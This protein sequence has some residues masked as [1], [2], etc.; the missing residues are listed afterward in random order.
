ML[1]NA[2]GRVQ[3]LLGQRLLWDT[4]DKG[5]LRAGYGVAVKTFT[6]GR[7]LDLVGHANKWSHGA[8]E[9]ERHRGER[10]A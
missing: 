4:G 6:C 5:G 9:K 1:V 8:R 10:G 3:G 7:A 2:V